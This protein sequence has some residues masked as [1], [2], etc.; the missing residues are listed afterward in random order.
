MLQ[1]MGGGADKKVYKVAKKR[2][3]THK[4]ALH[5]REEM[6]TLFTKMRRQ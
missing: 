6:K 5:K 3:G 4:R 2:L 1:L